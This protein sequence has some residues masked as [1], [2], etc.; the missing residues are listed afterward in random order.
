V[1]SIRRHLTFYSGVYRKYHKRVITPLYGD[2][3]QEPSNKMHLVMG[4]M[5]VLQK[6][7]TSIDIFDGIL[8]D[9]ANQYAAL[10]KIQSAMEPNKKE[11]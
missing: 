10:M 4:H 2:D 7:K 11:D 3:T 8:S 6:V 1:I 9:Y 5:N